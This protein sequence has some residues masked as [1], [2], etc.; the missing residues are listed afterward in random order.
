LGFGDLIEQ[1][2]TDS[3]RGKNTQFPFADLLRQSIYSRLAGY[4]DLNDAQR[5]SQDPTFRLIGSEKIWD[6]GVALTSRLQSFET[7]MLAQ[8]PRSRQ[9]AVTVC[10]PRSCSETSLRHFVH[11]FFVRCVMAQHCYAAQFFTRWCSF[12]A[13]QV[14]DLIESAYKRGAGVKG[15]GS[16]IPS[17]GGVLDRVDTL[18]LASPGVWAA[19]QFL[20][21][22][23]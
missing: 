14:G 3:R 19:Y 7:E 5:L 10:S 12:S 20:V 23:T 2:L 4:E 13:H 1:H 11:A 6:R 17:H 18:I 8:G 15:S 9:N 22:R 16:L 21:S